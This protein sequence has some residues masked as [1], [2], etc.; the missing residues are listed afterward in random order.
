MSQRERSL[1]P[2]PQAQV[3][4]WEASGGPRGRKSWDATAKHPCPLPVA[5]RRGPEQERAHQATRRTLVHGRNYVLHIDRTAEKTFCG[6]LVGSVNRTPNPDQEPIEA[7]C[8]ACARERSRAGEP[9]HPEERAF[10]ASGGTFGRLVREQKERTERL[11][12]PRLPS[13]LADLEAIVRELADRALALSILG[14]LRL[15]ALPALRSLREATAPTAEEL[16]ARPARAAR[17]GVKPGPGLTQG[18]LASRTKRHGRHTISQW[19]RGVEVPSLEAQ[20]TLLRAL[21]VTATLEQI[22][23]WRIS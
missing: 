9:P 14:E 21:G 13:A 2:T 7:L 3:R 16:A 4:A 1:P 23:A 8:I 22:Q 11:G 15:A 6:R 12:S 10:L 19:E 17:G 18:E 20:T 5:E